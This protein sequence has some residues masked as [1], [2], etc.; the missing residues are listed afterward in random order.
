MCL[1]TNS[2]LKIGQKLVILPVSGLVHHVKGGETIS[3]IAELYKAEGDEIVFFN[4]LPEGGDIVV[5]DILIIPN[6][7]KPPSPTYVSTPTQVPL[8][9]S[10]FIYPI[11]SPFTVSQGLHWY[12]AIDFT[13]GKCGEP[14][15]ASAQGTVLKIEYGWNSG[16]GNYVSILPPNGIVTTYGHISS[17][18]VNL[19]QEV[20]QG[21]MIATMGGKPGTSGAGRSTG[22]HVHFSVKG[23]RNPFAG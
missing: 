20:S 14:I 9:S 3:G 16:A 22:C 17:S 4:N 10:Y 13:H 12:N 2:N 18:F 19:G 21:Q 5:G 15:Y 23:A 8:A 7:K 11:S 1:S 6:G